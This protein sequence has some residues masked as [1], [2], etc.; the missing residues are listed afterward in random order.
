S[1]LWTRWMN[2]RVGRSLI[3]PARKPVIF[4]NASTRISLVSLN[5]AYSLIA[6]WM[7]RLSGVQVIHF[8]CQAG[9]SHCVLGTDHQDPRQALPCQV[10]I[11]RSRIQ[12]A[13]A[14]AHYFGSDPSL[15]QSMKMDELRLEDLYRYEQ[16]VPDDWLLPT[17]TIPLGQLVLPA[18]RWFLRRHNL[19]DDD[20]TRYLYREFI[21]SAWNVA[22]QFYNFM[23][24][25]DPQLLVVFNGQFFPEATARWVAHQLGIRVI[26]HEVGLHPM[27]GF[28]T[29]KEATIYPIQIPEE[30]DL[31]PDQ[32][33][34]MDAYLEKRFKG[35]FSMAGIKF[36]PEMQ[37]LEAS[38]LE[39]L[40]HFKQVVPVF[41]NVI[42]DTSQPHSNILFRDMFDWLDH[43]LEIARSHPETFFIIRAHP[44]ESR[45]G[46][47]ATESVALWVEEKGAASLSNV[48]FVGPDEYISSYELILRSKF[49]MVYNSTIGLEASILGVPVLAAGLSRY[50]GYPTVYF[51][52]SQAVYLQQFEQFLAA[53]KFEAPT[54][55]RRQARRFLY[56]HVFRVSL[57]FD[58]Y[59]EPAGNPGFVFFRPFNRLQLS[60]QKSATARAILAGLFDGKQFELDDD[61]MLK[62]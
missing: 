52:S 38:L 48:M 54:E 26:T 16:P 7:V 46:K 27:T 47:A 6:S 2:W 61:Y 8:V 51:P 21:I 22:R 58:E 49:V 4:F 37:G 23:Q 34:R 57:P 62:E 30:Y 29:D 17:R 31:G 5:A 56:Y 9:M 32:I 19:V 45:P 40:E 18:I 55:H 25:T 20:S 13:G 3:Q 35:K 10:C 50:T 59:L 24:R 42:F 11:K 39:R 36:W 28:F 14:Q 1:D 12:Y 53:K 41:T 33:A 43:V 15:A 60:V 44:D